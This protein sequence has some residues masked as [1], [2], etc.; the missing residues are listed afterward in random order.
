MKTTTLR[1]FWILMAVASTSCSG[2]IAGTVFIDANGNHIHDPDETGVAGAVFTV[3]RDGALVTSGV[4][5]TDGTYEVPWSKVGKEVCIKVSS[6]SGRRTAAAGATAGAAASV[7]KGIFKS[8]TTPES[9]PTDSGSGTSGETSSDTSS[10]TSTTSSTTS[11]A[12]QRVKSLEGCDPGKSV[13]VALDIPIERDL[14]DQVGRLPEPMDIKVKPGETFVYYIHYPASAT[15]QSLF[16]PSVIERVGQGSAVAANLGRVEFSA[17]VDPA[18]VTTST[19]LAEDD[20]ATQGIVLRAKADLPLDRYETTL[21]PIALAPDDAPITNLPAQKIIIEAESDVSLSLGVLSGGPVLGQNVEF[22]VTILNRNGQRY[23]G[24]DLSIK[25]PAFTA[26]DGALP[27]YCDNQISEVH[28][29]FDLTEVEKKLPSIRFKLPAEIQNDTAF[30]TEAT[31][32]L[33][34]VEEAVVDDFEFSIQG[35]PDEED[36]E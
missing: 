1:L 7:S 12:T 13:N 22:E 18:M 17:S 24:A 15:L 32:T 11:A 21:Q 29:V 6:A 36:A 26:V 23:T 34:G 8:E 33:P 14:A 3:N 25:L 35:P 30:K 4:T 27:D 9:T 16:L 10:T 2:R 28:C 31:L 5:Q 20:I 19:S